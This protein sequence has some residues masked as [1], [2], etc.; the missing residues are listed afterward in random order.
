MKFIIIRKTNKQKHLYIGD[1][2]EYRKFKIFS[3]TNRIS[4]FCK[5]SEYNA[6]FKLHFY[7]LETSRKLHL[8]ILFTIII[9]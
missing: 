9:E 4:K 5:V 8:Q 1:S 2:V 6:N 3:Q 7:I